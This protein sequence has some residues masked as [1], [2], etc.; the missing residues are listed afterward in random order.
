MAQEYLTNPVLIQIGVQ[1]ELNANK[2]IQQKVVVL[3]EAEKMDELLDTFD[4]LSKKEPRNVPKT[5][6]FRSKKSD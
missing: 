3:P 4:D 2:A 5:V 1:N 6:I